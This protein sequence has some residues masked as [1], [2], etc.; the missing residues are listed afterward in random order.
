[1]RGGIRAWGLGLSLLLVGCSVPK[2]RLDLRLDPEG[3]APPQSAAGQAEILP[4][5][6]ALDLTPTPKDLETLID[7]WNGDLGQR[8]ALTDPIGRVGSDET[9]RVHQLLSSQL[10]AWYLWIDRPV[11]VEVIGAKLCKPLGAT[12][13]L[14][15]TQTRSEEI[16]PWAGRL[17]LVSLAELAIRR[18]AEPRYPKLYSNSL[19]TQAG[20]PPRIS[21]SQ[22]LISDKKGEV[23]GQ[24][25]WLCRRPNKGL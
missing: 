22:L 7:L 18:G 6:W 12:E 14:F 25:F 5:A 10:N 21:L 11:P 1:M 4:G 20:L 16:R 13:L 15:L 3:F 8:L 2:A 23:Q 24:G 17:V 9:W 19:R